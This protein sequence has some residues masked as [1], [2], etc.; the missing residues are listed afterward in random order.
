MASTFFVARFRDS[1]AELSP[2]DKLRSRVE[3]MSAVCEIVCQSK[4]STVHAN[5][6]RS[7]ATSVKSICCLA[8]HSK[9]AKRID[10]KL[11]QSLQFTDLHVRESVIASTICICAKFRPQV[12]IIRRIRS[13][14]LCHRIR[15]IIIVHAAVA[16]MNQQTLRWHGAAQQYAK[17]NEFAA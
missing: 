14:S 7:I 16:W 13:V 3:L 12:R 17:C 6:L 8:L 10:D 2:S 11:H 4:V 9:I 5:D 15:T 1:V